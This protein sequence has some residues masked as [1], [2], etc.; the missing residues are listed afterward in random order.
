MQMAFNGEEFCLFEHFKITN[1][2]VSILFCL[3]EYS[4]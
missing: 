1:L 3:K 4:K 2:L